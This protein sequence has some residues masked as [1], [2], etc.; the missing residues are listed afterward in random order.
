[1]DLA[2]YYFRLFR[3]AHIESTYSHPLDD[4]LTCNTLNQ[5]IHLL[6]FAIHS[7]LNEM[8]WNSKE[9]GGCVSISSQQSVERLST[10]YLN[11][12]AFSQILSLECTRDCRNVGWLRAIAGYLST[13]RVIIM[14]RP[15]LKLDFLRLVSA[16]SK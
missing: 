5:F 10:R 9:F 7:R 8:L 14:S 16:N 2:C 3:F 1:M 11:K 12:Y 13:M 4:C 15:C 6:F